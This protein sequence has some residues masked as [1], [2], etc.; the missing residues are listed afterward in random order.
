MQLAHQINAIKKTAPQT[1][2]CTTATTAEKQND[3]KPKLIYP[4]VLG[5]L[6]SGF[7]SIEAATVFNNHWML[8]PAIFNM[9]ATLPLKKLNRVIQ[10]EQNE[11]SL[12]KDLKSYIHINNNSAWSSKGK[13]D[14]MLANIDEKN[15]RL[16]YLHNQRI[17][18]LNEASLSR[19]DAECLLQL[20]ELE[21]KIDQLKT[22]TAALIS[23]II[24]SIAPIFQKYPAIE[25][26]Q[27][28]SYSQQQ[29]DTL[30]YCPSLGIALMAINIP[31]VLALLHYYPLLESFDPSLNT[32]YPTLNIG[33]SSIRG[34]R[35]FMSIDRIYNY[36]K[37]IKL[38]K[39][40]QDH[41]INKPE[42]KQPYHRVTTKETSLFKG[43]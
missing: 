37:L 13:L 9:A 36:E 6:A 2:L 10:E 43:E 15:R 42:E 39:L 5:N 3:S 14:L 35:L 41:V 33:L 7:I 21:T 30:K 1:R 11:P 28:I 17:D 29:R 19:L 27:C 31:L 26:D 25:S 18:L 24:D 4:M 20:P 16:T 22:E 32:L 34:L 8:L 40:H 38:I 12:M 23:P